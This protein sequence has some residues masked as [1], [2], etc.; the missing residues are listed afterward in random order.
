MANAA[1][2]KNVGGVVSELYFF[3]AKDLLSEVHS[4]DRDRKDQKAIG[5]YTEL[6]K[7]SLMTHF[8]PKAM[9]SATLAQNLGQ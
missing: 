2:L 8:Q 6:N 7:Q 3:W 9:D 1:A 5:G 4:G